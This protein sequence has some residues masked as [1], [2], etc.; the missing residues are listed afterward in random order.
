MTGRIKIAVIR[1]VTFIVLSTLV[2]SLTEPIVVGQT[3]TPSQKRDIRVYLSVMDPKN[4]SDIF[5]KRIGKRY[6]AIQITIA[7]RY[8]DF[9]YLIHDV[10]LDL[11]KI[12]AKNDLKAR[13]R[14]EPSS[15]DKTLVRGVG[16]KGQILD[17]RNLTI[18]LLTGAGTIA[19]G[20]TGVTTF[21][22]SFAPSVAAFNGPVMSAIRN[23]FPDMTVNQMNRLNDSAYASNTLVP[24]QSAKVMVAFL[25]QA[26]LLDSR[27]R[28]IFWKEPTEC[29][30]E[31]DFRSIVGLVDGSF[32]EEKTES[33][34]QSLT[35][36]EI[37]EAEMQKFSTAN[38]EVKGRILGD[39]LDGSEVKLKEPA[40]IDLTV[41]GTE[42]KAIAFTLKGANPVQSGA[43]LSFE[44]TKNK[45]TKT[46]AKAIL[47]QPA[48]P[49][50][51]SIDKPQGEQGAI[52][53]VTLTGKTFVPGTFVAVFVR[54]NSRVDGGVPIEADSPKILSPT[55]IS[56]TLK[57]NK[58]APTGDYSITVVTQ[59]G[60]SSGLSFKV[61]AAAGG[62][63]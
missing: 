59:G 37:T 25:P 4:V 41:D 20:I 14:Y 13:G 5:G 62:D 16:E 11:T 56:V 29:F 19:G 2:I 63:E 53:A 49:T 8:N 43:S 12:Y 47:N 34:E 27:L 35:S 22:S 9:Q 45:E 55:S 42:E 36:V 28:A 23:A 33:L 32:I 7:N 61:V 15:E 58:K 44:V 46:I 3:P 51:D 52:V 38:F 50:L 57:I 21:G 17:P 18:R 31:V 26:V 54:P 39:H 40:G 30:K 60:A 24:K 1:G 10:S 48:A 6:V